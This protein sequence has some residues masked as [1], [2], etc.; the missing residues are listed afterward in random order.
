MAKQLLSARDLTDEEVLKEFVKRF[1]CDGAVLIYLDEGTESWFGRWRNTTGRHWVH[2]F[3]TRM[4][5]DMRQALS[6]NESDE[7]TTVAFLK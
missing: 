2:D 3:L 4:K 6:S 7:G 5:R 1:Q